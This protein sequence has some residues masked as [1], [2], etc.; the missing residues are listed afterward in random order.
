MDLDGDA[1]AGAGD[2]PEAIEMPAEFRDEGPGRFHVV[3]LQVRLRKDEAVACHRR[4]L[5]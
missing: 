1:T 5:R 4:R 3:A 2:P